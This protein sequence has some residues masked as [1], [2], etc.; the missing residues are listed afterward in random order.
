[1]TERERVIARCTE[2]GST[3]IGWAWPDDPPKVIGSGDCPSC[4][5]YELE[6]V[7]TADEVEDS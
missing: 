1:M 7:E 2:C 4:G 6:V 5:S 3:N